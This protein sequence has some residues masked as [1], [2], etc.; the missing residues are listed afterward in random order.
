MEITLEQI[1]QL[2][3]RANVGI[4]EAKEA[5]EK[6]EGNIVEALAQLEEENKLKPEKESLRNSPFIQKT[7]NIAAKL[8]KIRFVITK[9]ETNLLNIPLLPALLLTI[10]SLPAAIVAIGLALFT[11]CKIRFKKESG[12]EYGI[13]EKISNFTDKVTQEINKL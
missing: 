12:E 11:G 2:R 1:D 13:N 7:K 3:K 5:L 10:I 8:N 9:D 6:A 4:K